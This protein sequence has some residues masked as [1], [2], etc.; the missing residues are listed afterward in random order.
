MRPAKAKRAKFAGS[1]RIRTLPHAAEHRAARE[2]RFL[3]LRVVHAAE[4]F[5]GERIE[6]LPR[7]GDSLVEHGD[8]ERIGDR[9][10]IEGRRNRILIPRLR[11]AGKSEAGARRATATCAAAAAAA[12][13]QYP[14]H[15][16][17]HHHSH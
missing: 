10:A 12:A 15:L 9:A 17:H 7:T 8:D 5:A 16:C 14:H 4:H 3:A 6:R 11:H 2:L 1:A 13:V